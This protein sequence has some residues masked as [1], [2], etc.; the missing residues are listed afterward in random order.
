MYIDEKALA[1]FIQIHKEEFGEGLTVAEA[2]E[3]ASRLVMLYEVLCR[4]LP[5]AT[6]PSDP[7]D[8]QT[9]S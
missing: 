6:P 9:A 4:P 7:A 8:L 5:K 2:R 3:I 1:E